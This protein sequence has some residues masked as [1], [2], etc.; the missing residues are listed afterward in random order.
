MKIQKI[1]KLNSGKY[2]IEFENGDKL[3]TYDDVILKNQ[4]LF[5]KEVDVETFQQ[6]NK[7]TE[8]FD[9]YNKMLKKITT[10]LRSE[11]EIKKFLEK[12]KN[13]LS[14]KEQT[15]I[16]KKLKEIGMI[17]DLAF[18]KAYAS[19]RIFLSNEGPYKIRRGLEEH[20][21][22]EEYIEEAMNSIKEEEIEKKLQKIIVKKIKLNKKHSSYMLKQKLLAELSSNG[23]SKEMISRIF[24]ENSNQNDNVIEKEAG[25]IYEKLAR[26]YE[27][28]ELAQK[29]KEKLYQKGF[30]MTDINCVLEE[31]NL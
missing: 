31:K 9:V 11:K 26:K 6:L 15:S 22:C 13:S 20:D 8:Y 28:R 23:F 1:K 25:R 14:L 29:L 24:D 2:K 18:A 10:K 3:S 5:H 30:S 16:I 4:L 7:D 17:N 12:E 27:G 21:I 19:D